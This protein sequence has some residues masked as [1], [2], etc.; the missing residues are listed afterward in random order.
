[1][2]RVLVGGEWWGR[3][4]A[5]IFKLLFLVKVRSGYLGVWGKGVV[6]WVGRGLWM[7]C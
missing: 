3:G 2:G 4:R 1:M 7:R 6:L 5:K